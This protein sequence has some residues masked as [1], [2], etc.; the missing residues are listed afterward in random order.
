[1]SSL[2]A[3]SPGCAARLMH[4]TR[5]LP[6]RP[7]HPEIAHRSAGSP[8]APFEQNHALPSARQDEGM[9]Q[10]KNS[11]AHDRDIGA[12]RHPL[13]NRRAAIRADILSPM[14]KIVIIGGTGTVGSQT[15]RELLKRG[16][17]VRV[18]TRSASR[19]ASLPEGVEGVTGS[20]L[21]SR[22]PCLPSSRGPACS[23]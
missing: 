1:M 18:M 3:I 13:Q 20:M 4:L 2:R 19:I 7:D 17:A 16:A 14:S 12:F 8:L 10:P 22:N 6:D 11:A 9:R 21:A 23:S 5:R 15:V